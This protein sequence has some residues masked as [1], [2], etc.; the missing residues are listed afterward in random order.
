MAGAAEE[1]AAAAVSLVDAGCGGCA[2]AGGCSVV[3]DVSM[4]PHYTGGGRE[5]QGATPGTQQ[6]RY[7]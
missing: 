7:T 5:Q 3:G 6:N 1:A 2:A 4:V